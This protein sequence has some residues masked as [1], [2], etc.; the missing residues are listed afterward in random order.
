MSQREYLER[1]IR[2]QPIHKLLHKKLRIP[3]RVVQPILSAA[4]IAVHT[5]QYRLRRDLARELVASGQP[6]TAPPAASGFR[7]F[8]PGEFEGACEVA[9]LCEEIYGK[10]RPLLSAEYASTQ[11]RP[12]LVNLTDES[13]L[14]DH[15]ELVRFAVSRPVLDAA[16][17]YLG[18]VPLVTGVNL[19]WSPANQTTRSSQLYHLDDEDLTQ[20]KL[21]LAVTET[22]DDQGPLTFLPADASRRVRSGFGAPIGRVTD[23]RVEKTGVAEAAIR[24]VGPPGTAAFVD[25]S[26]CLH[27]GSRANRRDRVILQIQFLRFHAPAESTADFRVPQSLRSIDLDPVQRLALG[28]A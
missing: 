23:E 12:F 24:L 1:P 28:L 27:Y 6:A 10:K 26:R 18:A 8:A 2:T 22:G 11:S 20:L 17:A 16:I 5:G 4:K 3:Q 21:F 13:D 7:L 19:L 15:S 9:A 25:T 14:H